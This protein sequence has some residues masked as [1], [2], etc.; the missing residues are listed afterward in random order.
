M[1]YRKRDLK[2]YDICD[3]MSR[4]VKAQ[5]IVGAQR[6]Q[7]VWRLY[8]QDAKSRADLYLKR[9]IV[10]AGKP[11]QL[12]DQD[13]AKFPQSRFRQNE[14]ITVKMFPSMFLMTRSKR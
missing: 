4:C 9:S 1:I 12:Y 14:K 8:L 6:I 2:S 3:A 11:I 13:P 10:I 5:N 7:N